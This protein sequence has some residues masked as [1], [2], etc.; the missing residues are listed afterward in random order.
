LLLLILNDTTLQCVGDVGWVS[1]RASACKILKPPTPEVLFGDLD[2]AYAGV[3][4][5]K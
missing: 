2:L 5:E 4:C 1:G 3:M